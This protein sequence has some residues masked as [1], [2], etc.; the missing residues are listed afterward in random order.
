MKKT[1]KKRPYKKR[2]TVTK[3]K[4]SSLSVKRRYKRKENKFL[5]FTTRALRLGML[6]G[7]S[8]FIIYMLFKPEDRSKNQE[9]T[10]IEELPAPPVDSMEEFDFVE[11]VTPNINTMSTTEKLNYSLNKIFK[12]YNIN[13]TWIKRKTRAIRIQLPPELPAEI[14]VFDIIQTVKK[15]GLKC[16]NSK[17]NLKRSHST[18]MVVSKK[19]TLFTIFFSKNKDIQRPTGKI[20]IIIDDFGYYENKAIKSFL[21]FEYPITLSILPGQ[22]HTKVIAQKA[23]QHGKQILLHL[24]MEPKQGRVE[25][26]E[27]TILTTLSEEQIA[28]RVKKALD[29]LPDAVGVNNHMGS[30][31]TENEAV[32]AAVFKE[33]K[34]HNKM[35][36]DSKTTL[37]SVSPG[38]AALYN[39][40]FLQNATFLERGKNEEKQHIRNKL[41]LAAK[42]AER[43]GKVVIIGHPYQETIEVL[44]EELP[45][46]EKQGFIVV[47]VSELV[48]GG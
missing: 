34:R 2:T 47:P 24:P 10:I 35:F 44:K 9:Q 36:I 20:A 26:T 12:S 17:E 19:D 30:K 40:K 28:A 21:E 13:E 29:V 5:Q 41:K 22:K 14:I 39:L 37:N 16:I 38:V 11:E 18:L 25:D 1:N 43:K 8:A 31:A 6:F 15:L 33:L 7:V 48:E 46:L 4:R 32:M 42:I 27:F 45:K 23:K 3:R